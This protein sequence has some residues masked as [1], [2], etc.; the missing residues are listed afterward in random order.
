VIT[1]LNY[2]G[3]G[4]NKRGKNPKSRAL[5]NL[6]YIA[7]R[8][9]KEK[10]KVERPLFGP[11][12]P[13]R[14]ELAEAI[15]K[16]APA[17]TLYWRLRLSPDPNSDEEDKARDLDLWK[18]TTNAV[19]WLEGRLDR[20]IPF[21]GVEH[22]D[23]T[24]IRHTHALLLIQRHGREQLVT[25]E[26]LDDFRTAV[27]MM[28]AKQKGI[29]GPALTLED[30]QRAQQVQKDVVHRQKP[31]AP[32]TREMRALTLNDGMKGGSVR[33]SKD[34]RPTCP[35]CGVGM[36]MQK[37]KDGRTRCAN[38]GIVLSVVLQKEVA[39]SR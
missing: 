31:V 16:G 14:K 10:Q 26:I 5:D 19:Q 33:R 8:V 36:L 4:K 34:T 11:N 21:I 9:N 13:Q 7:R 2:I 30:L 38:C 12:G 37:L 17:N 25:P 3:R 18:L 39:W 35:N 15:I 24:E 28:A 6:E 29:D 32:H 1:I 20:E 23:H 27:G 22:D